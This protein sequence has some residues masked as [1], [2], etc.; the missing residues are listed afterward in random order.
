MFKFGLQ[1]ASRIFYA[2]EGLGILWKSA[3]FEN[4]RGHIR[5]PDPWNILRDSDHN[6]ESPRRTFKI[7][8][9]RKVSAPARKKPQIDDFDPPENLKM[10]SN[11][12]VSAPAL[13][14]VKNHIW[15]LQNKCIQNKMIPEFRKLWGSLGYLRDMFEWL[16]LCWKL[17]IW[18]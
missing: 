17:V 13:R 18:H 12:K 2:G 10:I 16:V 8:S 5:F 1:M 11:R 14:N 9:D 15:E 3:Y 7:L 4:E 6:Q